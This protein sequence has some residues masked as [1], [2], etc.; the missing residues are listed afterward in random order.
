MNSTDDGAA[1][2][3]FDTK[4]VR[5]SIHSWWISRE[6]HCLPSEQCKRKICALVLWF[7]HANKSVIVLP[8][9]LTP[10][11]IHIMVKPKSMA[12]YI[13]RSKMNRFVYFNYMQHFNMIKR[14]KSI[15]IPYGTSLSEIGAYI[16]YGY[17][18]RLSVIKCNKHYLRTVLT[19]SLGWYIEVV[20]VQQVEIYDSKKYY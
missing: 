20:F 2:Q 19:V 9:R 18:S 17:P 12:D 5:G 1:D 4:F 13:Y 10:N 15:N 6:N 8:F 14:V 3:C 7:P 11:E 16:C